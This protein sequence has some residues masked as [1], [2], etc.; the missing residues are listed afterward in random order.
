[1]DVAP[2]HG[3]DDIWRKYYRDYIRNN[4]MLGRTALQM[5]LSDAAKAGKLTQDEAFE[6]S[7]DIPSFSSDIYYRRGGSWLEFANR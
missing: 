3:G 4:L 2:R 1:M 5:T 7:F 6:L